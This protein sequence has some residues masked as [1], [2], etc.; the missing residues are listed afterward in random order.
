[1]ALALVAQEKLGQNYLYESEGRYHSLLLEENGERFLAYRRAWREREEKLEPGDFPL[2]LDLA[3][4]NGC[5]FS[6]VMCPAPRRREKTRPL[7]A[8]DSL[9]KKILA[10][11][12]ERAIPAMTL[13][14]ASEPLMNPRAPQY[15]AWARR[16]GIMDIRLGTNGAL[17]TDDC[18]K[19]LIDSGLT[20]LEISVDATKSETYAK[21]RRGGK[22]ET[23]L[24]NLERFW[25][26]RAQ[27]RQKTPLLRLSFLRLPQNEGELEPF[28]ELYKDRADMLSI[29][30]PIWFPESELSPPEPEAGFSFTPCPQ[31]FQRL[32]ILADG[33][34][35][36]CC[37]WRG[38]KLL[39]DFNLNGKGTDIG[40]VWNSARFQGLR[41]SLRSDEPPE[42]CFSCRRATTASPS[43]ARIP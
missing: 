33:S 8:P 19:A 29:Q 22:L 2:S 28:I 1:M 38:E 34:L 11:A 18:L 20:R 23:L 9:I 25:A 36:P 3:L 30:N 35:W 43:P 6:C 26:L 41:A 40:G 42:A 13:G 14:L 21:I 10:E 39:A 32:G 5:A 31:P 7:M 16:A 4:N 15:I 27:A 17:L 12:Q 24:A 37:S